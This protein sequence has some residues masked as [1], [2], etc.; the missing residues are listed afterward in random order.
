MNRTRLECKGDIVTTEGKSAAD[1]NRT[2][3]EC[4]DYCGSVIKNV[5]RI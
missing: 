3:L 1:L 2:R 5:Y 4:K